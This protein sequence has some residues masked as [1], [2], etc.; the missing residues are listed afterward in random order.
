MS[1]RGDKGDGSRTKT[2]SVKRDPKT[3]SKNLIKG[4]RRPKDGSGRG[5][6]D[7][8]IRKIFCLD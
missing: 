7:G 2:S 1:R 8:L 5:Y 6:E 4:M 3:S